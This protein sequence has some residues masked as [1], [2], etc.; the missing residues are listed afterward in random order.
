M[1][2]HKQVFETESNARWNTFKWLSRIFIFFLTLIIPIVWISIAKSK[3][4]FLPKLEKTD[5]VK[6]NNLI[7]PKIL[8]KKEAVRYKGFQNYLSAKRRLDRFIATESKRPITQSIRAAFFVDWDAQSLSSLKA[9]INKLNMI[10][11]EWLFIDPVT[12]TLVTKI[13]PEA[14]GYMRRFHVKILPIISNVNISKTNGDF[15]GVILDKLMQ[16]TVKRKKLIE[17]IKTVL[18]QNHFAGINLDFE[19]L[20]AQTIDPLFEFQKELYKSLHDANLLVTQDIVPN[21]DNYNLFKLNPYLDYVFLMAYDEHFNES[22][23]GPI[24]EQRWIEKTL[25]KAAANIDSKKIVLCLAAYGYDWP[26]DG[27]GTNVTYAEAIA[28]A[29]DHY[30]PIDFDNNTYNCSFSYRDVDSV[31]HHVYFNDAAGNFNTMRFA[32]DYGVAG[33]A[34]WRLGAEDERLWTFY[35]S[36]LRSDSIASHLNIFLRLQHT[37]IGYEKP[38]YIGDGEVLD[39]I[40]EPAAGV[41]KITRDSIENLVSEEEYIQLP[42]KYIIKKF[43]Q[44]HNQVLLTFDD[45]P[46]PDFTPQ[47]LKILKKE[48]VPAAFFVVGVNV[49][50]NLSVLRQTYNDGFEIGNHTFT[51]PNIAAVGRSRATTEIEA[52]RLLIESQT[53]RSTILFRPPYNADAEPTSYVELEPIAIGKTHSYYAIGESI[54][55]ED[56]D[57]KNPTFRMN[58]DTIYNRIIREYEANPDK[59]IILLHDAGGPRQ[60]TVDA[61]PRIIKYFKDK[62]IDFI[63]VGQLL[64][65]SRNQVMPPVKGSLLQADSF[66]SKTIAFISTFLSVAFWMA[67]LL[68][69]FRIL[70][71]GALVILNY[72]KDKKNIPQNAALFKPLVSVIVPAYNEELNCVATVKSLLKQDYPALEIIFVDDG[73]KDKTFENISRAFNDSPNVKIFTKENGGKAAAL[74]YG[75]AHASAEFLLCIDADTQLKKNAISKMIPYFVDEKVGA[76]AGNVKVGNTNNVITKWQSIEYIT[77][78]NFDRRAFDYINGITVV[79]GAIGAFRKKAMLDAG[80]FTIDSLAEDCDLTIRILREGYVI[81]NC[82]EAV[83]VTEAPETINQF[84]KQRFRWSYGIM[85]SF[86]KNRDAC[87]NPKYKGLGMVS[88][89]NILL[90]QI[91]LPLIAPLADLLFFIGLI[92]NRNDVDSLHQILLYY[93]LFLLIDIFISVVAFRFEKEN[94][95]RLLWLLPQRFA[96]R[97]LMYIVIFRSIRRAIK[98]QG[99][100]WG[101]LKRTGNAVLK[102]S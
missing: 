97:Q 73:S 29:K 75:I 59:G 90:F 71:L 55:P 10:I 47:I 42:T 20:H 5:F 76:V 91:I 62:K 50:S 92:Y 6:N 22:V 87:F 35:N 9:H 11:P 26:E 14:L 36:D 16:N 53:G 13:D 86:W 49:E 31:L 18:L 99:Q 93:G 19:E 57:T 3:T 52:T 65:L 27:Y 58:A 89:P 4:P 67:I 1:A 60:A 68:G 7:V 25:D 24:S 102:E 39:M 77:A 79:P 45:G 37:P 81:R 64:H 69:I 12:D 95:W 63:S 41:M 85:Q 101:S 38:D 78:Q 44:V 40:T 98:G 61:L 74:N 83:A 34:L 28:L 56:W 70:F 46:D 21:D 8:S 100:G 17:Q 43:G 48:N 94:Y 84:L 30:A 54:D 66:A 72:F 33:T 82:T 32:D 2:A 88:L 96:Y 80:G 15:D 23:P 51:H